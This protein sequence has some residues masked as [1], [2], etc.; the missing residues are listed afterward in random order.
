MKWPSTALG[1]KPKPKQEDNTPPGASPCLLSLLTGSVFSDFGTE[2]RRS[3]ARSCLW[4]SE[5]AVPKPWTFPCS[6]LAL[7]FPFLWET[8]LLSFPRASTEFTEDGRGARTAPTS[9][10]PM[11]PRTLRAGHDSLP[12]REPSALRG[13]M[14]LPDPPALSLGAL[15]SPRAEGRS[16]C[17]LPHCGPPSRYSLCAGPDG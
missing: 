13:T 6:S 17:G 5:R 9:C 15:L 16:V 3:R 10:L 7:I 8:S 12:G 14:A 1:V 2:Q 4:S 11:K